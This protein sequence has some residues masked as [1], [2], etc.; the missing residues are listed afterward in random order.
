MW[1]KEHGAYGQL[2]VPAATALVIAGL[3]AGAAFVA[4]SA[5]AAFLAHEPAAVL[6]GSRGPR[7]RRERGR[8]AWTWLAVCAVLG[9]AALAGGL[10]TMSPAAWPYLA[11]PAVPAAIVALLTTRRREKTW[12]GEVAAAASLTLVSVPIAMA[13]GATLQAAR[14][15]A[16]PFLAMFTTT[17]FAVRAI[18]A[19]VRGGG[20][21]NMAAAARRAA[22]AATTVFAAALALATTIGMMALTTL[23]AAAPGLVAAA[24]LIHRPPPAAKLRTVGW[25]LVATSLTTSALVVIGA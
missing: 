15:V 1:P 22:I 7:A 8:E 20:D 21:A 18:I 24:I 9:A 23:A 16:I 25:T 11:C 14:S 12:Y 17:T 13:S 4:V 2:L 6:I 19:R 3:S 5:V 10:A